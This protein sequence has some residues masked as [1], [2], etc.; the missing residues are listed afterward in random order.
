MPKT[1]RVSVDVPVLVDV[2]MTYDAPGDLGPDDLKDWVEKQ[3]GG[4]MASLDPEGSDGV[5]FAKAGL[6][7]VVQYQPRGDENFP[8]VWKMPDSQDA[9]PDAPD[10]D[11]DD[12]LG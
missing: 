3:V 12:L 1:Q 11:L 10:D 8:W 4:T 2:V 7:R 5:A 6:V 9:M